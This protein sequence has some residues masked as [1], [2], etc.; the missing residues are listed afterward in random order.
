MWCHSFF[1]AAHGG[2]LAGGW[3]RATAAGLHHSHSH[4]HRQI[5]AASATYTTAH[6]NA[7]SPTHWSRPGI[8]P[9][10][11]WSQSD[12]LPLCRNGNS[13][14]KDLSR[15]LSKEDTQMANKH[16]ERCSTSLLIRE[17]KSWG[18]T[19]SS[20]LGWLKWKQTRRSFG[21]TAG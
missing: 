15:H 4:S 2:S 1:P 9:A 16:V 20:S 17:I 10:S 21:G 14:E 12:L 11:S 18:D 6:G 5:Q 8:K 3:V 19:T 7:R 13:W